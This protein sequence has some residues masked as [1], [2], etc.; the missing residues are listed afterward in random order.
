MDSPVVAQI[1][2]QL[3]RHRGCPLLASQAALP[4][5]DPIQSRRSR[6]DT[7]C[8]SI[9]FRNRRKQDDGTLW[10]HRLDYF[11]KDMSK[12]L[13]EYPMITADQ[14]RSRRER[15]K[16]VKMLARDFIEGG[17]ILRM[18]WYRRLNAEIYSVS[19]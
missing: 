16:R 10:R 14:L 9:S 6:T 8:R 7:Q 15:P 11:P 18:G 1:F 2:R 4:V 19:S 17:F 12:E 13:Q 3:F 5:R